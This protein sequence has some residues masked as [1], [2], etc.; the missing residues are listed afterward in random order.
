MGSH[1]TVTLDWYGCATFRLVVPGDRDDGED[2]VVF[3]DA[4]IDRVEGAPGP[5]LRAEDIDRADWVVVGHSHFDHL[6]GAERIAPRTGATVIGSHESVRVLDTAGVPLGQLIA[7]AGGE[8]LTVFQV[9][10]GPGH[11]ISVLWTMPSRD[12]SS[13]FTGSTV[14][15][16]DGDG[17]HE[18]LYADECFARVYAGAGTGN[19]KTEVLAAKALVLETA[20]RK[21]AGENTTMEAA[22]AKYF[23]SEMVGRV[24]DRAVQIFGGAGYIADYGIE[25]LYRDVRLFRIYE[26]TSQIQQL[27]IARETLKRGG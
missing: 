13:R 26:G 24:A 20:S 8:N 17:R 27:I 6:W 1:G 12:G 3:L 7:V 22:A 9:G 14:F 2:L 23:A 19:G 11:P 10:G 21:D 4:Y 15:D 18:V 5:G 25:R 16:F